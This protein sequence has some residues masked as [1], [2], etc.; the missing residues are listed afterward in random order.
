MWGPNIICCT[1]FFLDGSQLVTKTEGQITVAFIFSSIFPSCEG[2]AA[3]VLPF[4]LPLRFY[5]AE[6]GP[7]QIR[8]IWR[9][10]TCERHLKKMSPKI[11]DTSYQEGFPA[12]HSPAYPTATPC[13]PPSPATQLSGHLLNCATNWTVQLTIPAQPM[14]ILGGRSG[15]RGGGQGC[16]GG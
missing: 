11:R 1:Y 10:P 13:P 4:F 16:W 2:A 14:Q 5:V 3:P 8:G 7:D 6:P 9:Q 12:T 15:L